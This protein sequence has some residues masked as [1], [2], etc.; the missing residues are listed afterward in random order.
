MALTHS[1][2][3]A[4]LQ[5]QLKA[6][7][8]QLDRLKASTSHKDEELVR[9]YPK[10]VPG[11][12]ELA[13]FRKRMHLEQ[14]QTKARLSYLS[15]LAESQLTRD[16]IV[17]LKEVLSRLRAQLISKDGDLYEIRNN[18]IIKQEKLDHLSI[19]Y[20]QKNHAKELEGPGTQRKAKNAVLA[21]AMESL[22]V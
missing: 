20:Y 18:L 5:A 10:L 12:F 6:I 2:E 13:K 8:D 16:T 3:V 4:V 19:I 15:G 11:D 1:Q 7:V 21:K 9:L 22:L 14:G 17:K